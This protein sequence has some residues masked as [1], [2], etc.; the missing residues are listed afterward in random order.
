MVTFGLALV[1]TEMIR[2]GWGPE[3]LQVEPPSALRGIVFVFD[4]PFPT[5]RLFLSGAASSLR[6]RFGNF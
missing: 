6:W 1:L 4:E 3:A 2:L 5:Y